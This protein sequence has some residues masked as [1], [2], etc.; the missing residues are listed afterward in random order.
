MVGSCL[1]DFAL[2]F[3]NFSILLIFH[4]KRVLTSTFHIRGLSMSAL[5]FHR[6]QLLIL[7]LAVQ[8]LLVKGALILT[9]FISLGK[10]IDFIVILLTIINNDFRCNF[11]LSY[12]S[13]TSARLLIFHMNHFYWPLK[14]KKCE[15]LAF[16]ILRWHKV[17]SILMFIDK[18]EF[19]NLLN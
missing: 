6:L 19:C 9:I 10:I 11:R 18:N 5:L 13:L 16:Y 1:L 12:L 7:S 8:Q 2:V 4:Q 14:L 15:F 17:V 3:L